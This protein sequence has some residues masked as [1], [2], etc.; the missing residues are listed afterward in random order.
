MVT[1]TDQRPHRE[2]T[3]PAARAEDN[4]LDEQHAGISELMFPVTDQDQSAGSGQSHV[5]N[6]A[7]DERERCISVAA[8]LRAELGDWLEAEK[9][10]DSAEFDL[11]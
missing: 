7:Q 2:A 9:E 4:S 11:N 8:Y 1:T 10:E 3:Q 6:A 5:A